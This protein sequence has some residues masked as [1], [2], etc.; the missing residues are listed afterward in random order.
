[1]TWPTLQTKISSSEIPYGW[2]N[3]RSGI[4]VL[5]FS[6]PLIRLCLKKINLS[7]KS[8]VSKFCF[9][10]HCKP[11]DKCA[12]CCV[13]HHPVKHIILPPII[14]TVNQKVLINLLQMSWWA[15]ITNHG[16]NDT[17]TQKMFVGIVRGT[18]EIN[19][20]ITVT[21][22]SNSCIIKHYYYF[23]FLTC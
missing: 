13:L 12:S 10:F 15:G 20:F 4:L 5:Y 2:D 6:C 18:M 9:E 22:L 16:H 17:L 3:L 1:V 14:V 8:S 11:V 19:M 21:T 7:N 23:I